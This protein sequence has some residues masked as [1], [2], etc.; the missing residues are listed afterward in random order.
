MTQSG[1]K[2]NNYSL[3]IYQSVTY[4]GIKQKVIQFVKCGRQ[5]KNVEQVKF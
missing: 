1:I 5:T 2:N 4:Q 3:V